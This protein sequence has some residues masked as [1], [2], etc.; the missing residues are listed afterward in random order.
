MLNP[1]FPP[2][3][4]NNAI[5]SL[6][7]QFFFIYCIFHSRSKWK[8]RWSQAE[9]SPISPANC[10]QRQRSFSEDQEMLEKDIDRKTFLGYI[11][12]SKEPS[13]WA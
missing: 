10:A 7:F 11:A 12:D 3:S 9:Q 6:N 2:D 4:L 8:N 1:F 13:A 5:S